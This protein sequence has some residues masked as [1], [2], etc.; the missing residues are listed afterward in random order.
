MIGA[1]DGIDLGDGASPRWLSIRDL[2]D[3]TATAM[4]L[5]MRA[6][7][8]AQ[9]ATVAAD[10]LREVARGAERAVGIL[11]SQVEDRL[12][13]MQVA[14]VQI[15]AGLRVAQDG[16]RQRLDAQSSTI[17]E[18]V[19]SNGLV[20]EETN[21]VGS[22]VL[23]LERTVAALSS[24]LDER[25]ASTLHELDRI[26]PTTAALEQTIEAQREAIDALLGRVRDLERRGER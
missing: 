23:D 7:Q 6:E 18:L 2:A 22:R 25:S 3:R 24:R 9:R 17:R 4:G 12:R 5:G 14:H 8:A 13:G 15:V 19:K 16:I 26:Q 11:A 20:S 10:Q 1:D 21:R